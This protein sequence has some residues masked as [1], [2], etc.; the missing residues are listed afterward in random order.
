MRFFCRNTFRGVGKDRRSGARDQRS[1]GALGRSG[2]RA[3][4]VVEVN[5]TTKNNSGCENRCV[6][7]IANPVRYFRRAKGDYPEVIF[8]A[9][10][11]WVNCNLSREAESIWLVEVNIIIL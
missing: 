9:R 3:R 2:H 1:E 6:R 7:V 5:G 11:N 8:R 4:R 10:S